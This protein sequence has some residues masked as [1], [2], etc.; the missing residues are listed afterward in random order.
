MI[1]SY[2]FVLRYYEITTVWIH[3]YFMILY[4]WKQIDRPL[5]DKQYIGKTMKKKNIEGND[6]LLVGNERKEEK[7]NRIGGG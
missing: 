3:R 4:I 2:G 6:V 7:D 5:Q 1:S